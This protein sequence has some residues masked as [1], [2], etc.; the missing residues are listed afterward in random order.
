MIGFAETRVENH[1]NLDVDPRP[2]RQENGNDG[3]AS[4]YQSFLI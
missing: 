4:L 1:F 3:P 2:T